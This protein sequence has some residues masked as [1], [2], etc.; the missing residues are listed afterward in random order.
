MDENNFF[1]KCVLKLC[2]AA[3][4][5]PKQIERSGLFLLAHNGQTRVYRLVLGPPDGVKTCLEFDDAI[6]LSLAT[7]YN[8]VRYC[9]TLSTSFENRNVLTKVAFYYPSQEIWTN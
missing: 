5:K 2:R 6:K 3:M 7:K 1:E 4:I 8:I 9:A